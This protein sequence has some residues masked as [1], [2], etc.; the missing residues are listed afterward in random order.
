[1]VKLSQQY[2]KLVNWL[3]EENLA[4]EL[5]IWPMSVK[6]LSYRDKAIIDRCYARIIYRLDC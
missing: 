1:M 2:R 5:S 6:S 4:Y 3:M